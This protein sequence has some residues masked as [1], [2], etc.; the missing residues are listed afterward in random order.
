MF[1]ICGSFLLIFGWF[2]K[3]LVR[4][5]CSINALVFWVNS[6][7]V[8]FFIHVPEISK[9]FKSPLVY[10]RKKKVLE[11]LKP[12]WQITDVFLF[13]I[14]FGFLITCLFCGNSLTFHGSSEINKS[15]IEDWKSVIVSVLAGTVVDFYYFFQVNKSH[16]IAGTKNK[17]CDNS[18][19]N[20]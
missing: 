3:Y 20:V 10:V 19:K 6:Q 5:I 2:D 11:S 14:P 17:G 18:N 1:I 13:K 12:S 16:F 9:D 15:S 4:K 8:T 7:Y